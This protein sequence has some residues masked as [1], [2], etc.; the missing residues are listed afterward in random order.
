MLGGQPEQR[1][2]AVVQIVATGNGR[3]RG[4]EKLAIGSFVKR[5]I[6]RH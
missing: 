5:S 3:S 2:Q 6:T 4:R 1:G